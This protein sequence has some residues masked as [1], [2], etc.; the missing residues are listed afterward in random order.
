[1]TMYHALPFLK[2]RLDGLEEGD[3]TYDDLRFELNAGISFIYEHWDHVIEELRLTPKDFIK[4]DTLWTLFFPGCLLYGFDELSEPRCYRLLSFEYKSVMDERLFILEVDHLDHD[5]ERIGYRTKSQSIKSFKSSKPIRGLPLYP[6]S[7]H[8]DRDEVR[9]QLL[10]RAQKALRL[11]GRHIQNYY[12]HALEG[13]S[14]SL[15]F[16]VST[17]GFP[18]PF[19]LILLA[20]Y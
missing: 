15:K 3:E 19:F 2:N 10:L 4:F 13:R 6:L 20:S 14:A 1:M 8:P 11:M 16:N 7:L 18:V 12:G 9:K 5:G 17:N